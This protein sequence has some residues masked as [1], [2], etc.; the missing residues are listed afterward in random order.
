VDLIACSMGGYG[1]INFAAST[2]FSHGQ[3]STPSSSGV[4]EMFMRVPRSLATSAPGWG[5]RA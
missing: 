4:T 2:T 5:T 3:G 1:A